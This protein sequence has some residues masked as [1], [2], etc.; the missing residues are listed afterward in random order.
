M[1][2]V[3]VL[4]GDGFTGRHFIRWAKECNLGKYNKF[5][6]ASI[7][8]ESVPMYDDWIKVDITNEGSITGAF[9]NLKIEYVLNLAGLIRSNS[10]S[11][12]HQVNAEASFFLMNFFAQQTTIKKILLVGSAAEYGTPVKLPLKEVDECRPLS[13]YGLSKL[14]QTLYA[15]YLSRTLSVPVIIARTFNI[16]GHGMPDNLAIGSFVS[17]I[18][19]AK[20]GDTI[21]TGDLSPKRDYLTI[22]DVCDAYWRLLMSG[23]SGQVYNVCAGVPISMKE[24][25]DV[26]ITASGKNLI[27]EQHHELT[28]SGK[29]VPDIYGD[30]SL[31]VYETGWGQKIPVLKT[32]AE[33]VI[34]QCGN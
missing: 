20:N 31:L 25:L 12:L 29:D 14:S 30:N 15:K 19:A 1:N 32:A 26:M 13:P 16:L 2:N 27:V 17:K 10:Y 18:T 3:L 6:G 9:K 23:K 5:I 21:T 4:G 28:T 8:D 24:I 22:D 11:L 33:I 7:N 34:Q